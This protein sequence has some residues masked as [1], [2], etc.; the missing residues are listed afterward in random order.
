MI[1]LEIGDAL[2]R[3]VDGR[4]LTPEELAECATD[5]I[6]S[7]GDTAHPV[8]REQALAFRHHITEIITYYINEGIRHNQAT[9]MEKQNAIYR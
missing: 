7:I 8:I 3:T 6:I 4:G 9:L 1:K 5:K 2:V